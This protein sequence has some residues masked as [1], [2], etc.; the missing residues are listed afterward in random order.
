MITLIRPAY[1]E[2]K[3]RAEY[4]GISADDK[5]TIKAKNGE[6]EPKKKPVANPITKAELYEM[7]KDKI[8][9]YRAMEE[10]IIHGSEMYV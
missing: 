1:Y 6:I 2:N 10:A 4:K 9:M 3:R 5:S 8:P 7:V